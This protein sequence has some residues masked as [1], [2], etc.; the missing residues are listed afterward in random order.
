MGEL[1]ANERTNKRRKVQKTVNKIAATPPLFYF[2]HSDK[3]NVTFYLCPIYML[4][5]RNLINPTRSEVP[6]GVGKDTLILRAG[7]TLP[8]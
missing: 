3:Q 2:E 7:C 5:A 8:Y 4:K 6:C 1:R